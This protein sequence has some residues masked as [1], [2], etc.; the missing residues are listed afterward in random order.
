[1]K[2]YY[3]THVLILLKISLVK[4]IPVG[5]STQ[6]LN[7]LFMYTHILQKNQYKI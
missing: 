7:F 5:A 2:Q 6:Y 3:K 1:M 4:G